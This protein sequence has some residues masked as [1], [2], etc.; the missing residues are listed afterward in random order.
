LFLDREHLFLNKDEERKHGFLDNTKYYMFGE[1]GKHNVVIAFPAEEHNPFNAII[2]ANDMMARFRN[3]K[4]G[5]MVG[6]AGG[7]PSKKHDIRLGDIVVSVSDRTHG[8]TLQCDIDKSIQNQRFQAVGAINK[9]LSALAS[10]VHSLNCDYM[11][12]SHQLEDNVNNVFKK[13]RSFGLQQKYKRPDPSSD[14][15]YQTEIIRLSNNGASCAEACGD[16][17]S[18]LILR[19]EQT[20]FPIV[21]HGLIASVNR[22]IDDA[23]IRDKRRSGCPMFSNGRRKVG[24]PFSLSIYMRDMRLLGFS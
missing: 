10:A 16:D 8:G 2:V 5:L 19:P 17:P 3:I 6:I 20:E 1:M 4:M 23:S 7:V 18:K 22:L 11:F 21:H 24:K 13:N 9:P 14:R 15:L 12:K